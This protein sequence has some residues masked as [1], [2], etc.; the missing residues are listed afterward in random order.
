MSA[1]TTRPKEPSAAQTSRAT[2]D[3]TGSP[4]RRSGWRI[5]VLLWLK[6]TKI[7]LVLWTVVRMIYPAGSALG[8]RIGAEVLLH[9]GADQRSGLT[10]VARSARFKE[11]YANV[12]TSSEV[13]DQLPYTRMNKAG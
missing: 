8:R 4:T 6:A 12:G 10:L 3:V 7:I 1:S 2:T 9:T 5:F 11:P 13:R